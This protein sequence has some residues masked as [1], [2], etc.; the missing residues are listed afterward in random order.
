M[1][2][3]QPARPVPWGSV[4][5]LIGVMIVAAVLCAGVLLPYVGGI[6]LLAKSESDRF[7]DTT[8]DLQEATP[9]E[10]TTFYANDGKTVLATIFVQDRKPVALSQIPTFL[11]KA[12]IDTEDRRFYSHHGVDLRGLIRSAFNTS[13]GDTQGGSTL[14]MQYVKQSRY[15]RDIGDITKQ[16]SDISQTID[17]KLQDA[18][19]AID[20]EKRETKDQI[21]DNYFNIAFFGENAYSI[22]SAAETYFGTPTDGSTAVSHLTVPQAALLV[23]PAAGPDE[24]RPV[25][26]P[27]R[28]SGTPRPGPR[29]HGDGRR[30]DAGAGSPVQID[31]GQPVDANA[32]ERDAGLLQHTVGDPECRLLLRLREELA[33]EHRR[34]Q[35]RTTSQPAVS[36]SSRPSMPTIQ[37]SAQTAL[38][39][40]FPATSPTTAV[41]PVVDPSTGNVLAM[42]SSKLYGNDADGTHL[43]DQ[44]FTDYGARSAST[45]KYFTMLTA[46]E[47]GAPPTMTLSANAGSTNLAAANA[48][49]TQHCVSNSTTPTVNGDQNIQYSTTE[50]MASAIAKSSNTYFVALEDQ[51]LG[52][53]LKPIEATMESLGMKNLLQADPSDPTG[54]TTYASSINAQGQ[55]GLTLGYYPTSP[56][57]LTSAYAAAANDGIYCPPAPVTS[58]TDKNGN[59]LAVKRTP[60]SAQMTPQVARTAVSLLTGDTLTGGTTAK[61]FAGANWYGANKSLIAGKTGTDTNGANQNTSFWFVGMTPHLVATM[62]LINVQNPLASITGIPNVKDATAQTTADASIAGQYWLSTFGPSIKS[63]TWNWPPANGVAGSIAVPSVIGMTPEVAVSTLAAKGFKTAVF[64]GTNPLDCGSAVPQGMVGYYGP[65]FAAPGHDD[66]VL[67]QQRLQA[68]HLHGTAQA[69]AHPDA[70]GNA[71]CTGLTGGNAPGTLT[72]GGEDGRA[73]SGGLSFGRAATFRS[74]RRAGTTPRTKRSRSG[75]RAACGGSDRQRGP[76]GATLPTTMLGPGIHRWLNAPQ[77]RVELEFTSGITR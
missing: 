51:F 49:L 72:A 30:P 8:C 68:V 45:Y 69:D 64:G 5:K 67:R 13:G 56:L 19:C 37:K 48:Y 25:P 29:Q 21:L 18:K 76:T 65:T 60:C 42:V 1:T 6:G 35:R 11:Q 53:S 73:E 16:Q 40:Q 23:G 58:I 34:H 32:A 54:K 7:L 2:R 77:C 70:D 14:T 22:E 75:Q 71:G 31:P 46:L 12:L 10:G 47:A 33:A 63:T 50:T 26:A 38:S 39:A 62:A 41:E 44:I 15:Y 59:T 43:A 74:R 3:P 36:R 28:R 57:E 4:F 24:L 55:V 66:H 20:L 27:D 52:C 61:V 9:P 17:R